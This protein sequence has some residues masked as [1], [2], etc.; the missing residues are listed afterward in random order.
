MMQRKGLY[1]AVIGLLLVLIMCAGCSFDYDEAKIAEDLSET[2][3]ETVLLD[4]IQV[5]MYKGQPE[6][7]VYG[8]KAETYGK[9][10]E[11]ILED[12]LF[13]E[14]DDA[15]SVVTEGKADL[16]THFS[17][18]DNAQMEGNLDF[19][20]KD[21]EAGITADYLFWDDEKSTL[22]G[23]DE[24]TITLRKDDGSELSGRGFIA[25]ISEKQVEFTSSVS[26]IWVDEDED[27]NEE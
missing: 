10:K 22:Q 2:V 7:R 18:T 9:K 23:K 13:H 21:E 5:R 1:L 25:D 6:Y 20:S 3:P 17:E 8:K 26:G 4:F 11:T 27:D 24:E 15:G 19:Y 12:V 16:V 14:F